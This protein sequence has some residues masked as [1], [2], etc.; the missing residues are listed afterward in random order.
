PGDV[1]AP[2]KTE[3][4]YHI[5]KLINHTPLKPFDSL[6][7]SIKRRVDNDS[8]AGIA[9]DQFMAKIKRQHGF[10]EY[11][12]AMAAL[13][14]KAASLP[15]TGAEA[16]TL[17]ASDFRQMNSPL[18]ELGGHPYLQSDLMAF[19]EGLTR[20]R[21]NAPRLTVIDDIYRLYVE[22][23]VNDFEEH[24][25]AENNT[26]FRNLMEEYRNGIMIFE[27]MDRNV[28]GKASRDTAGLKAFYSR[29]KDKYQWEP[30]FTGAVYRFRDEASLRKGLDMM[31]KGAP[32]DEDLNKALNTE[33][34]PDNF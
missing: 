34:A 11:P 17:R 24:H 8:R 1:S 23:T 3:Y 18:F 5:L 33:S 27:L 7:E 26:D 25:L 15:D 10:K 30:G 14:A 20:G 16:N 32:K 21:V 28:W 6:Q 29:Q 4:G 13:K 12:A 22:R 19:A 2:V 31:K 9:R